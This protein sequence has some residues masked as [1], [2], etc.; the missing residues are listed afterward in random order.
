MT[1]YKIQNITGVNEIN[2]ITNEAYPP[3]MT[4]LNI[5]NTHGRYIAYKNVSKQTMKLLYK[6]ENTG[7]LE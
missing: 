1:Y 4:I 5:A 7:S 2:S 3:W 6:D